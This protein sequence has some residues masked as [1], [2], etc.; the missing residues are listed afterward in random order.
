MWQQLVESRARMGREPREY[1]GEV[2]LRVHAVRLACG[3]QG[4][5]AREVDAS[6][7]VPDKEVVLAPEGNGSESALRRVV[8]E[9]EPRVVEEA[10][11]RLPL[12]AR[13]ADG[14]PERT[15]GRVVRLR[16]SEPV[17]Q[18]VRDGR[19]LGLA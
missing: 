13:I 15:L 8:V 12:P 18:L 5:E 10:R 16:G 14:L 3:E 2:A 11:Q 4:E 9:R 6:L 7:V 1:V 17:A 19:G